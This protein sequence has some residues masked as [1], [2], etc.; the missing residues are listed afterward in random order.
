MESLKLQIIKNNS[1]R[2]VITYIGRPRDI[3]FWLPIDCD[4]K[5]ITLTVG[6]GHDT[7]NEIADCD[8]VYPCP[9]FCK[10]FNYNQEMR[11]FNLFRLRSQH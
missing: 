9:F 8:N 7:H 5:F 1:K 2:L 6:I 10:F 4:V 3:E 11:K